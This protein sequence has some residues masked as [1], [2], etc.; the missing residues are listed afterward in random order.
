VD[1]V[2]AAIAAVSAQADT[3][4][5][6]NVAGDFAETGRPFA[7]SVPVDMSDQELGALVELIVR[8]KG[9][10]QAP[11]KSRVWTPGRPT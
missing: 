3:V 4:E 5:M 6:T 9:E 11:P 2:D 8:I 7:L 1:K 10:R